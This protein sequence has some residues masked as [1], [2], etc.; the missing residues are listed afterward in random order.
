MKRLLISLAVFLLVGLM[1]YGAAAWAAPGEVVAPTAIT[2]DVPCPVAGCTQPDGAC[3]AASAAPSPDGSFAM[4][5][6]K[7]KACSDTACHA[8]DRLTTHYSK[9]SDS[10]LNLWILAPV[11]FT[12]GLVLIVRK[13]R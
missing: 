11:L 7:V 13:M 9:P 3:H 4:A 1:A 8:W 5:C 10:S 2:P 6:P 12:V